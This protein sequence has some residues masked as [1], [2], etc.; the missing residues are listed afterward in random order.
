MCRLFGFRSVIQSQVH[1][2]LVDA[3]NALQG[4]SERHPDGWGV[5]YYQAGA[6]HIIKSKESALDDH[7]FKRVSGIVSS[8]TVVAHI[9]KATQGSHS[10]LNTHPFQFGQWVFAH[11]GNIKNFKHHRDELVARITPNLRRFILGDTD[12][13]V[14][15]Y[16][17]LSN[18]GRTID[19]ATANPE[20]KVIE[21]AVKQTID[22]IQKLVEPFYH[23]EGKG[24]K[25]TYLTFILTNGHSMIAHQGGQRLHWSTWKNSCSE[26]STCPSFAPAC[27]AA[28]QDGFVNHLIFT[29]EPLHGENIWNEMKLGEMIGV[30]ARMKLQR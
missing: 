16:L 27:E 15:F 11:N 2:S 24:D 19:L 20:Y 17:M 8:Q 29:S 5:A 10:I 18:L 28:T 25:E 7:L 23:E 9:R 6:P 26:R 30:D 3:E 14:F 13:E 12:S 21:N 22:D 1:K 4:Q